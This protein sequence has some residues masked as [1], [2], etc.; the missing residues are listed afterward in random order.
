MEPTLGTRDQFHGRQVPTGQGWRQ[1]GSGTRKRVTFALPFV[2]NLTLPWILRPSAQRL[3]IVVSRMRD[4]LGLDKGS[5]HEG[6][7]GTMKHKRHLRG[8][9]Q[10]EKLLQSLT[11]SAG[12]DIFL[13]IQCLLGGLFHGKSSNA[14]CCSKAALI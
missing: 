1:N 7:E 12:S 6:K 14:T 4:S 9:I 11:S 5:G 10:R 8:G 13:W 2:S 3:E